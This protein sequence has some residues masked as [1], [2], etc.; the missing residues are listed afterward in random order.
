MAERAPIR[1]RQDA[2]GPP[3]PDS[4]ARCLLIA[5]PAICRAR[6]AA[7]AAAAMAVPLAAGAPGRARRRPQARPVR[8][9]APLLCKASAGRAC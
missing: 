2:A 6:S 8:R 4:A 1:R 5:R 3:S 7:A 9:S